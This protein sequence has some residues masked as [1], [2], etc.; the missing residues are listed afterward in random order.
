[1]RLVMDTQVRLTEFKNTLKRDMFL[2]SLKTDNNYIILNDTM[3]FIWDYLNVLNN[4]RVFNSFCIIDNIILLADSETQ[5]YEAY[6][7][8]K[9]FDHIIFKDM[10]RWIKIK[11]DKDNRR[12]LRKMKIF[13]ESLLK[14]KLKALYYRGMYS[15][16][17]SVLIKNREVLLI[18]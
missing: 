5:I 11:Y 17:F 10:T 12:L 8:G 15:D 18:S 16:K 14:H 13:R 7:D 6:R 3:I 9:K 1:M 2:K 4:E